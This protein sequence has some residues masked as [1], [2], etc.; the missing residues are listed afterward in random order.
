MRER[1]K[2]RAMITVDRYFIALRLENASVEGRVQRATA[3]RWQVERV[4]SCQIIHPT[5]F[6]PFGRGKEAFSGERGE[7]I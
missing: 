6:Y 4:G 7:G 1:H 2:E 5:K 3:R